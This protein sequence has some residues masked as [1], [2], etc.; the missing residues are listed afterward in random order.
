MK[1]FSDKDLNCINSMFK[2]FVLGLKD[3]NDLSVINFAIY[4]IR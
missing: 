4:D 1:P 2:L 3:Q